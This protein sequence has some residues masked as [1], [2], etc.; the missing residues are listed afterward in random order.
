VLTSSIDES[1]GEGIY[2]YASVECGGMK[3]MQIVR[4]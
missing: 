4:S 3:F 1:F 2:F